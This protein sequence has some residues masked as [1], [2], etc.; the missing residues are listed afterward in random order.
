MRATIRWI[1]AGRGAV[2]L[3]ILIT[4]S[5][6]VVAQT[7]AHMPTAGD[8]VR[9]TRRGFPAPLVGAMVSA[10]ADSISFVP[11]PYILGAPRLQ[12]TVTIARTDVQAFEVSDGRRRHRLGGLAWG[13][14]IGAAGGAIVGALTYEP[15]N[16]TGFLACY[17][18]PAN[19]EQSAFVGGAVGAVLGS[20]AGL[21]VGA[22]YETEH[23]Q[24]VTSERVAQVRL[25]PTSRGVAAS[26][27]L[28]LP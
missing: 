10:T 25:G 17:L 24:R 5:K 22:L 9:I 20:A 16:E 11:V 21:I 8:R 14:A 23:W 2:T 19:Q 28:S 15:C 6:P 3:C 12:D 13:F 27:S 26:V 4:L 18:K 1:A 7:P